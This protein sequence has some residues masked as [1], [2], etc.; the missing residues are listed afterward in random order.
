LS[1]LGKYQDAIASYTEA[2]AK[3]N[4]EDLLTASTGRIGDCYFATLNYAQDKKQALLDAITSYQKVLSPKSISIFIKTQTLYKLGKSY[5]LLE[6]IEKAIEAYHEAFYS[7]I[8][9]MEQEKN[10]SKIWMVKSAIAL[11]RL[12]Q[13]KNTPEGA[14]AAIKILKE[15]IKFNIE[16]VSDFQQRIDEI[17]S[18]YKLKE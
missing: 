11:T 14:D 1:S 7:N 10:P 18:L 8:I 9:C 16:P 6:E 15:L 13:E 4:D 5:E 17:R 3:S 12:L 2:R